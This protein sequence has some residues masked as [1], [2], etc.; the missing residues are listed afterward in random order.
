MRRWLAF[1]ALLLATVTAWP[2]SARSAATAAVVRLHAG[3]SPDFPV[4]V[5]L[6]AHVRVEVFGCVEGYAWCDV[7]WQHLRGWVFGGALYVPYAGQ[8]YPVISVGGYLGVGIVYFS[9]NDYWNRYYVGRPWYSS[10]Y[11]VWVGRPPP[12]YWPP[13]YHRPPPPPPPRP[14]PPPPRPPPRPPV[15]G[16]YPG[17]GPRP[18]PPGAGGGYNPGFGPRPP[19][20]AG[21]NGYSPGPTTRPP[22]GT[23]PGQPR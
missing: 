15:G 11:N 21:G 6:P 7:Q 8:S 14:P 20:G 4:I 9:V 10:S 13:H 16:F 17:S 18:P 2:A 23:A 3:P 22:A 12:P 5:H 1:G 19:P